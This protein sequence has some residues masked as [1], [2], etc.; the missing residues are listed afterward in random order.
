MGSPNVPS[1]LFLN[2]AAY[3]V[4]VAAAVNFKSQIA[5]SLGLPLKATI[6]CGLRGPGWLPFQQPEPP[7]KLMH[8]SIHELWDES[9]D[10]EDT[11]FHHG[12]RGHSCGEIDAA[13]TANGA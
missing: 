7:I 2:A 6:N 1:P 9:G 4:S 11:Q 5:K 10:V 12:V 13:I 3:P 8:P